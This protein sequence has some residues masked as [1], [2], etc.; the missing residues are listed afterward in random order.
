MPFL[1]DIDSRAAIKGSRDPLGGQAIWTLLG[2]QVVG[3]LTT[4]TT[5]VRDF[6]V[7]LLGYWFIEKLDEAG[8]R[9]EPLPV[10]IRWEQLASY[11]RFL[12]GDRAFRGTTRT[13]AFLQ[14]GARVTLSAQPGYQ[15]LAN[16][17][18]YGLWGLYSQSARASGLLEEK[19]PRLTPAA[20][21][22][23]EKVYRDLLGRE[24]VSEI[25]ERLGRRTATLRPKGGDEGLLGSVAKSLGIRRKRYQLETQ[26]FRETLVHGGP[27]DALRTNGVQRQLA[28]LFVAAG[29]D[30]A[31]RLDGT[32]VVA[33][34]KQA[35]RRGWEALESRLER[36]L[37]A[38]SVI[39]PATAAF[40]Y[41]LSREGAE[42]ATVVREIRDEWGSAVRKR[43][44]AA[45]FEALKDDL[46]R[47][48]RDERTTRLWLDA[49][50]CLG[51]G[52]I[53][54]LVEVLIALNRDVMWKRDKASPWVRVTDGRLDVH[55]A[56]ER[57]RL[58]S[59]EQLASYWV[60][61]YFLGSLRAVALE[62]GGEE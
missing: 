61:P 58:P 48:T 10:F 17:K 26:T 56:D 40:L 8:S 25:V 14:D 43:T 33:V 54:G 15:T 24:V 31:A 32:D 60:S 20:R 21:Q 13:G 9:E 45:G 55:F 4:N 50:R 22:L 62:L 37:V 5:S 23:A 38:E 41:V 49:A 42:V 39:A 16:Q 28:E 47:A 57:G 46:F 1:T 6:V 44:D 18:I 2:R 29:G 19:Q 35:G 53:G 7:L 34:R 3:G 12:A 27:G 59:A 36:I 11:A 52:D 30:P 51:A